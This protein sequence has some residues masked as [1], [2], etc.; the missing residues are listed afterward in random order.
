MAT[1][2]VTGAGPLAE[3]RS[4][5]HARAMR[6]L[7]LGRRMLHHRLAQIGLVPLGLVVVLALLAPLLP[8]Q[9]PLAQ[10]LGQR[11][12]PPSARHWFGTDA[13]G[14]DIFA[15]VLHG[16]RPTLGIVALVL[17]CSAPLGLVLGAAAGLQGGWLDRVVMRVGDIF[18]AFPR[19]VLALAIAAALGGGIATAV[20][21]VAISGWP[22][23]A[24]IARTDARAFA[25]SDFVQAAETIGASRLRILFVH[26]LPLCLP[27]VLVR[28][29]LDAPGVILI[30][31]GL[32][33]LGLGLPP[34]APEWGAMVAA[35]RDVIFEQWW[36]ATL[37]GLFI[38]ALSIAFNLIGDAMRDVLDPREA[39]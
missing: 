31:A 26:I 4:R 3:P 27:S 36:V 13:L 38:F 32:G 28:A 20:L 29:A 33:F 23:Y 8:L 19:L 7:R 2:T 21:A 22:I 35:G 30:T 15:R 1:L 12:L 5:G 9:D 18:L 37:P 11:L 10:D 6:W 17:L 16:A 34:P 14:R 24:R 39:R 25:R